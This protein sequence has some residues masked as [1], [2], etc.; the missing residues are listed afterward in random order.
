[1]EKISYFD[2]RDILN[3]KKIAKNLENLPSFCR[4]FVIGIENN[5]TSL[6]RLNYTLDLVVFFD[7]LNKTRGKNSIDFDISD[8]EKIKCRDI[9]EFLSYLSYYEINGVFRKNTEKGKNRKLSSLKSLFKY[10]FNRDLISSN[11]TTKIKSGKVATK[12]IVRLNNEETKKLFESIE[13]PISFSKRQR[14]YNEKTFERDSAIITLFLG[15]G[16]RISELVGLNVSD[17]DFLENAFKVTRKGGNQ[18]VLYFSQD[19]ANNLKLW[20]KK[21]SEFEI[22]SHEDAMFLSIQKRR[23][24]C[25]AVENL[26]QKFAKQASPLKKISPHKLRS[27]FGTALYKKTRDIFI[28]ADILGHK[29]VNTTKKHYAKIDEEIR[30]EASTNFSIIEDK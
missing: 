18:S 2:K 3:T 10:L 7:F 20:L 15:T 27:T 11:V 24:C 13:D 1:M 19:V 5:T 14:H 4:D 17:F 23:I 9:D 26:V 22:P 12:E 6:T 30:K 28:V 29:D 8:M 25:R 16:I 21:R